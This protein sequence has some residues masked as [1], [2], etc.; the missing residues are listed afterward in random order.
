LFSAGELLL[1]L[2]SCEIRESSDS[3]GRG[4]GRFYYANKNDQGTQVHVKGIIMWQKNK[5]HTSA[6]ACVRFSNNDNVSWVLRVP[7]FD[8]SVSCNLRSLII[9]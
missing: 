9:C 8:I 6:I 4:H 1:L 5:T 2:S 7:A 3:L